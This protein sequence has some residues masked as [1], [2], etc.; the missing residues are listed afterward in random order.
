MS[1]IDSISQI[2]AAL[3]TQLAQGASTTAPK[4]RKATTRGASEKSNRSISKLIAQRVKSIR[5]DD[6]KRGKKVFRIFLESVLLNEF[7][8]QLIDDT[9]FYQMVD[10]IQ[11]AME[12]DIRT[13]A[14]INTAVSTLLDGAQDPR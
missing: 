6:P 8:E 3:R 2:V 5:P 11:E 9:V 4:P 13:A 12:A 1:G 14:A 7:G 10:E